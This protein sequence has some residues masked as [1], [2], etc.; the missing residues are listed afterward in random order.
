MISVTGVSVSHGG[1]YL[2]NNIT[3][4]INKNDR[5]GLVGRN[6]AGKSTLMKMLAGINK[7]D[8]GSISFPRECTVGYLQQELA[9]ASSRTVFDETATALEEIKRLEKK[10]HD[11]TELVTNATDFGDDYMEVLQELHDAQEH[12]NLLDSGNQESRIEKVLL[13]LGFEREQFHRPLSTFSGGWQMRVELA[14]I[15]L[16][17]PNLLLLDEPTNH[18]DIESIQWLEN[19]LIDYEGS[20]LLVSHDRKFLD[21]ITKRTV[22]ITQGRVEDYKANYSKYLVLRKERKETVL[23]AYRN[24]QNEIRQTE[25]LIDKFR[26][27]ANKA[28]FA[29]SLI[30]QLDRMDRIEMEDE[31]L[32]SIQFQFPEAPRSGQL[33]LDV[34]HLTKNYGDKNVI[35]NASFQVSR[36]D[37]IAFVGK[38]GEGKT[39]TAKILVGDESSEGEIIVG[40]NVNIGYYAQHQA[41]KLDGNETVFNTIDHKATGEMRTKVRSL[42]GAFLFRGDDIDKKVKVL[43]GGE[44]SRLALACL[45]LEKYNLLVFDEP[46]NHLD[47][48]SKDIL[49]EALMKFNG[50]LIIV[51]HDRDFLQGLTNK[52]FY[53]SKGQIQEHIGEVNEF[54]AKKNAESLDELAVNN[55]KKKEETQAKVKAVV[56]DEKELKKKQK[57]MEKLEGKISTLENQIQNL[58]LQLSK[59]ESFSTSDLQA[60]YVEYEKVKLNLQNAIDEWTKMG[61]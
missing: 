31:D 4:L 59:P 24:Q 32:S 28:K 46:T 38:N 52:T 21:N 48:R 41:D 34:K 12:L 54:L 2:F 61:S 20:I 14:K 29:Q 25:A 23:S 3:F 16:K 60:R 18:L 15:L 51:S 33:V 27:K 13:G 19:F 40:H 8:E 42:L 57:E 39:T 17:Q 50:T 55:Q 44:K 5:I 37:R 1:E 45:L 11:L 49:K 30:K 36:G 56:T 7:P 43:S 26:A 35:R 6:G 10:V 9:F 47:I 53:F 22:E 58:E